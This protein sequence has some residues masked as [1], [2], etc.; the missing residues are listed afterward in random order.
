[1]PALRR[2]DAFAP[3]RTDRTADRSAAAA[4]LGIEIGGLDTPI[5][6]DP[7]TGL[8]WRQRFDGLSL[9]REERMLQGAC[10]IVCAYLTGMR[11]S[12]VQAMQPGLRVAEQQRRW[13]D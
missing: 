5:S 6:I 11:D 8:P 12:E 9:A 13:P 4:E 3:I 7:D 10:Y 1:M 2:A